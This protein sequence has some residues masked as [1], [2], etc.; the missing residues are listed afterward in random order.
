MFI[1]RLILVLL[2]VWLVRQFLRAWPRPRKG[3]GDASETHAEPSRE[4]VPFDESNIRDAEFE[5][6]DTQEV[7]AEEDQER[8]A[9]RGRP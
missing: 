4:P 5:D 3:R 7:D 1:T 9:G 6:V 2:G 8:G